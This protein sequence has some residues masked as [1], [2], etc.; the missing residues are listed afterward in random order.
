MYK[1]AKRLSALL[2]ANPSYKTPCLDLKSSSSSLFTFLLRKKKQQHGNTHVI[3]MPTQPRPK[4]KQS[5]GVSNLGC[6]SLRAEPIDQSRQ[7]SY[8]KRQNNPKQ[9]PGLNFCSILLII[10]SQT[11]HPQARP[12]IKYCSPI[13]I[14][15]RNVM[16]QYK[17]TLALS[18]PILSNPTPGESVSVK[19]NSHANKSFTGKRVKLEIS[20]NLLLTRITMPGYYKLRNW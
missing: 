11:L 18:T 3:R 16:P 5:L 10:R 1:L 15:I 17:V 12:Q 20:D 14:I 7:V 13:K 4:S 9:R 2:V 6:S 19:S 8:R